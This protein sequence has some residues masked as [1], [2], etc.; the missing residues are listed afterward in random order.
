[1]NIE[2]LMPYGF[3]MVL[4][5]KEESGKNFIVLN[6]ITSENAREVDVNTRNY[7]TENPDTSNSNIEKFRDLNLKPILKA[8]FLVPTLVSVAQQDK[9]VELCKIELVS[10]FLGNQFTLLAD[11]IKAKE[12]GLQSVHGTGKAEEGENQKEGTP[13]RNISK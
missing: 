3:L 4:S 1:M 13:I 5:K 2:D 12:D 10:R 11:S 6:I 9:F 7:I 8:E